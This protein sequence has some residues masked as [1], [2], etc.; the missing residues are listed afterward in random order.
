MTKKTELQ[1]PRSRSHATEYISKCILISGGY[2]NGSFKKCEVYNTDLDTSAEIA[3]LNGG[4]Y[5]HTSVCMA[6]KW[7][8]VFAG[9]YGR[10]LES[11]EKYSVDGD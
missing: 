11:I 2:Y 8:Y 9:F 10:D 4:R 7:C 6:K 3:E 1:Y 5:H